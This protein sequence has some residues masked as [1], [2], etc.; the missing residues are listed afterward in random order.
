ML[1]Q[2]GKRTIAWDHLSSDSDDKHMS[3]IEMLEKDTNPEKN[4]RKINALYELGVEN[5]L[6][7]PMDVYLDVVK[8]YQMY[9]A[10]KKSQE[11][12]RQRRDRIDRI[13]QSVQLP[14]S[15]KPSIPASKKTIKIFEPKRCW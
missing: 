13:E 4:L 5:R 14:P 2:I 9:K 8:S 10:F 11:S 3:P 7:N 1:S 15:E 6:S 12:L